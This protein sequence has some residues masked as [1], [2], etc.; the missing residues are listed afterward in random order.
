MK[1]LFVIAIAGFVG[2]QSCQQGKNSDAGNFTHLPQ[3]FI[4]FEGEIVHSGDQQDYKDWN[5]NTMRETNPDIPTDWLQGGDKSL[6]KT[7][8]YSLYL[9][10]RRMERAWDS[11]MTLHF[12]WWNIPG[13]PEIRHIATP[14]VKLINI[15]PP[16]PG[17]PWIYELT[18]E[19]S[20]LDPQCMYFG[21]GPK[22][23][24]KVNDWDWNTAVAPNTFYTFIKPL[25]NVLD[26]D[27]DGIITAEEY[28]DTEL[29]AVLTIYSP[30]SPAYGF[31]KKRLSNFNSLAVSYSAL[32]VP[33]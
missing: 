33:K 10:V 15:V 12:G 3:S 25:D 24:S 13:D 7:G 11:P 17:K 18:G 20:K 22:A 14:G 4:L 8:I 6:L 28:P 5:F 21:A 30:D 29:Y 16:E 26:I 27:S 31:L 23:H 32:P 19:I 9:E 2:L 1:M